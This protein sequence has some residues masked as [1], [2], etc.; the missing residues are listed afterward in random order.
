LEAAADEAPVAGSQ[1]FAG[2]IDGRNFAIGDV[3]FVAESGSGGLGE[4]A[5]DLADSPSKV[6]SADGSDFAAT[7]GAKGEKKS[8]AD[9]STLPYKL[10]ILWG[11]K[12]C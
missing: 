8:G 10:L 12:S 9:F 1:D 5:D 6:S 2:G 11:E 4:E 7:N 3:D